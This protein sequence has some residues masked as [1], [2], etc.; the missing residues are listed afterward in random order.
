MAAR[1]L[2][3]SARSLL[4]AA[5]VLAVVLVLCAILSAALDVGYFAAREGEAARPSFSRRMDVLPAI[6]VTPPVAP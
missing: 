2:N 1:Y 6:V 5:G 3:V 4:T